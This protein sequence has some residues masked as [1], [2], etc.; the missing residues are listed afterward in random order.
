MLPSAWVIPIG[1]GLIVGLITISVIESGERVHIVAD[2]RVSEPTQVVGNASCSAVACHGSADREIGS[3]TAFC[4]WTFR[5]P[6]SRAYAVLKTPRSEQI[7]RRLG[8]A[9]DY[10]PAHEDVRCLACHVTPQL[11]DADTPAQKQ[12]HHDG[13]GCEACHGPAEKWLTSHTTWPDAVGRDTYETVGMRWLNDP[14]DRAAVCMGCH[15]GA[16]A[17]DGVPVRDVTHDLIAAGHPR[18]GFEMLTYHRGLPKHWRE[19]ERTPTG[20]RSRGPDFELQLWLAG[21]LESAKASVRLTNDR[22][23]RAELPW[24]ELAEFDCFSCHHDLDPEP[25]IWRKRAEYPIHRKVGQ[26]LWNGWNLSWPFRKVSHPENRASFED[27]ALLMNQARPNPA[28]VQLRAKELLDQLDEWATRAKPP[29][30]GLADWILDTSRLHPTAEEM[31]RLNWTE[32]AQLYHALV[33]L[34]RNRQENGQTPTDEDVER[35]NQLRGML[36]F[37]REQDGSWYDSPKGYEPVTPDKPDP[38][39]EFLTLFDSLSRK[40]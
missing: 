32:A 11:A 26:P 35:L 38:K 23:T 40:R 7:A 27:W 17:G 9:G 33:A 16:P 5:D 21:Q 4:K 28:E 12:R 18:L 14:N 22:V 37:P 36:R 31:D 3:P 2:D 10:Q 39:S 34:A 1:V 6:H 29:E 30:S 15:V 20:E 24:P 8:Q 25:G 19:V 13:V